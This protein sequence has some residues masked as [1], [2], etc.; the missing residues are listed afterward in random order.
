MSCF[1]CLPNMEKRNQKKQIKKEQPVAETVKGIGASSSERRTVATSGRK[2]GAPSGGKRKR[3][4]HHPPQQK[5]KLSAEWGRQKSFPSGEK[6]KQ[7]ES[8]V[9]KQSTD[10]PAMEPKALE[11]DALP[12]LF[13]FSN[14][15]AKQSIAKPLINGVQGSPTHP[16]KQCT[17]ELPKNVAQ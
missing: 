12:P 14:S 7:R 9:P 4:Y 2:R 5:G 8:F 1:P 16:A 13:Q 10:L 15:S 3:D 17:V 6:G 11:N